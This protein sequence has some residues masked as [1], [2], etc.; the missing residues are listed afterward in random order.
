MLNS[1]VRGALVALAASAV[2]AGCTNFGP[3]GGIGVGVGSPYGYG[4]GSDYGYNRYGYYDPYY[5][6]YGGY[7]YYGWYN[8]YY[9]PGTG[10]WV[11]DPIGNPHPITDD[12]RSYW[13]NMLDKFRKAR[14]TDAEVKANWSGFREQAKASA[15]GTSGSNAQADQHSAHQIA[16][17]RRQA[18]AER[19]QQARIERQQ[20]Q[21]QS[22]GSM[23]EEMMERRE[24]RRARRS[25]DD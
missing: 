11:Y 7:P 10:F 2:L 18:R 14:G 21:S 16:A 20:V 25:G 9:Y 17:A 8:G 15:A 4:Y 6:R 5:A 22:A 19:R 13:G 1:R 23:R 3:Y 24:A 12:Q